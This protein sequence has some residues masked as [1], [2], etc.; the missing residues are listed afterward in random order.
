M[1]HQHLLVAKGVCGLQWLCEARRGKAHA[2]LGLIGGVIKTCCTN[3]Y[4]THVPSC[5]LPTCIQ[6][7]EHDIL[8]TSWCWHFI[9][10]W[11]FSWIH[12][13]S[14]SFFLIFWNLF[15]L[16]LKSSVFLFIRPLCKI[17]LMFPMRSLK[18]GW[19]TEIYWSSSIFL[20]SFFLHSTHIIPS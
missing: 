5:S 6:G 1:K 13:S 11:I 16:V 18:H 19:E 8:E 2:C 3:S 17:D 20:F 10:A 12:V 14:P 9:Q 4:H 7:E 15:W